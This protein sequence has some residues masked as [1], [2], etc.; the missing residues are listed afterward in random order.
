MRYPEATEGFAE[1]VG[2]KIVEQLDCAETSSRMTAKAA[3]L[4]NAFILAVVKSN[5]QGVQVLQNSRRQNC[6]QALAAYA[7]SNSCHAIEN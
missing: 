7:P 1:F 2:V 3:V 5:V 4:M 6:T